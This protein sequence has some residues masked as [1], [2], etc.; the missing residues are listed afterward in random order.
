M[1]NDVNRVVIISLY[2]LIFIVSPTSLYAGGLGNIY[3]KSSEVS[4]ILKKYDVEATMQD[5]PLGDGAPR[6]IL[7]HKNSAMM[8]II[9]GPDIKTVSIMIGPSD[10]ARGASDILI[11]LGVGLNAFCTNEDSTMNGAFIKKFVGFAK[12]KKKT[13]SGT[14][15]ACKYEMENYK[16]LHFYMIT[17]TAK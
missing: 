13:T 7:N 4:A 2:A 15:G 14:V 12:Q 11:F 17:F 10:T 5:A 1:M 16:V 9:G 6:R 8:E 3:K